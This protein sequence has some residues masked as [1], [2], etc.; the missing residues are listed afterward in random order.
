[1][2]K[3]LFY[4]IVGVFSLFLSSTLFGQEMFVRD[5]LEYT[6]TRNVT[7]SQAFNTIPDRTVDGL[8]FVFD[9]FSY[10]IYSPTTGYKCTGKSLNNTY[11]VPKFLE[12]IGYIQR[13]KT[14]TW[15]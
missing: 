10:T 1:M 8:Y 14:V 7:L 9:S 15:H 6:V 2:K 13:N 11:I 12:L 3:L 4:S 5:S